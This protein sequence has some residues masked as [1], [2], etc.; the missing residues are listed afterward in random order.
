M[1]DGNTIRFPAAAGGAAAAAP[2]GGASANKRG[3]VDPQALIANAL[4]Y[5]IEVERIV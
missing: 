2:A 3:D 1:V 5:A 4:Q